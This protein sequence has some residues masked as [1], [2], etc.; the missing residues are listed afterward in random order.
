MSPE[1]A[2]GY[3]VGIWVL[4]ENG[5]FFFFFPC[6]GELRR[7]LPVTVHG[8]LLLGCQKLGAM[9]ETV[10]VG[11]V[12][13]HG[14]PLPH[15]K[16]S[17][18]GPGARWEHCCLGEHLPGQ[19]PASSGGRRR[20][21][22]TWQRGRGGLVMGE[23]CCSHLEGFPGGFLLPAAFLASSEHVPFPSPVPGGIASESLTFTPLEDMIFLK[24][25]EPVEPNGLITQYEVGPGRLRHPRGH[26][27]V[28]LGV[29]VCSGGDLGQLLLL[30]VG[31]K[32]GCSVTS[33]PEPFVWS[34]DP[35]CVHPPASRVCPCWGVL[36]LGSPVLLSNS[37]SDKPLLLIYPKKHLPSRLPP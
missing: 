29:C 22:V 9:P 24:W 30:V 12:P 36:L 18:V 33:A 6:S 10:P 1:D 3:G 23:S 26:R 20:S 5:I 28:S 31:I 37:F 16:V 17:P 8:G 4:W 34:T 32:G 13:W 7:A 19:P 15:G 25:E 2:G 21:W 14:D 35:A 27:G 11:F